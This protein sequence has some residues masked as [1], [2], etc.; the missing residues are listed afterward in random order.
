MPRRR[1]KGDYLKTKGKLV[2]H[3]KTEQKQK[4]KN[5]VVMVVGFTWCFFL[6]QLGT[7]EGYLTKQGGLVKVRRHVFAGASHRK[8]EHISDTQI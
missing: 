2:F 6:F 4:D 5:H 7:K 3:L 1:M 8:R